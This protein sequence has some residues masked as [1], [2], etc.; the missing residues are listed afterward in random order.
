MHKKI[1]HLQW[2]E[3]CFYIL[4]LVVWRGMVT[5]K[6]KFGSK[7]NRFF[8]LIITVVVQKA[9]EILHGLLRTSRITHISGLN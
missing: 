4:F 9:Y 8:L 2:K 7:K 3:R 1:A 6:I 5:W